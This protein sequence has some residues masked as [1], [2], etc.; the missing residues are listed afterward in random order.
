MIP[1][2]N[3]DGIGLRGGDGGKVGIRRGVDR[4]DSGRLLF[5]DAVISLVVI[6]QVNR[7][8]DRLDGG[9]RDGFVGRVFLVGLDAFRRNG[10]RR[11]GNSVFNAGV[12]RGDGG[13]EAI[14]ISRGF[15]ILEFLDRNVHAAVVVEAADLDIGPRVLGQGFPVIDDGGRK[16]RAF[17]VDRD[18][19]VPIRRNDADVDGPRGSG[20]ETAVIIADRIASPIVD[21]D[22]VSRGVAHDGENVGGVLAEEFDRVVFGRGAVVRP[23]LG[24]EVE[25]EGTG[26]RQLKQVDARFEIRIVVGT[27]Q[28]AASAVS[29]RHVD[30][31][32]A[33]IVKAAGIEFLAPSRFVVRGGIRFRDRGVV[34][35]VLGI[36]RVDRVVE[37]SDDFV[38]FRDLGLGVDLGERGG[39][40]VRDRFLDRGG[41]VGGTH[42]VDGGF[43]SGDF[44]GGGRV[45]RNFLKGA[46]GEIG[47]RDGAAG[48]RGADHMQIG[49]AFRVD[50]HVLILEIGD[51]RGIARFLIFG[52]I[53]VAAPE[54]RA[55]DLGDRDFPPRIGSV[56]ERDVE[57]V[58]F[59]GIHDHAAR[60]AEAGLRGVIRRDVGNG[61]LVVV[62]VGPDL[63]T[64]L[65]GI[66]AVPDHERRLGPR[67]VRVLREVEAGGGSARADV[68]EGEGQAIERDF[69]GEPHLSAVSMQVANLD[70][71]FDLRGTKLAGIAV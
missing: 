60:Y 55:E 65:A 50:W 49:F 54:R 22:V 21:R 12:D 43:R 47:H 33:A 34:F 3:G 30:G 62:V 17:P 2:D 19:G 53:G 31:D 38:E 67:I 13:G 37:G 46:V 70:T 40:E 1:V 42:L 39:L 44:L 28:L 57:A 41:E 20:D 68:L 36:S 18:G 24:V 5:S 25:E 59:K 9:V 61:G 45:F 58:I 23:V 32:R 14:R 4:G 16:R 27:E 48:V 8:V 63:Q 11:G 64:A 26:V 51:D 66:E 6:R 71:A 69:L 7:F 56:L 10:I 35:R 29:A 52:V 15:G